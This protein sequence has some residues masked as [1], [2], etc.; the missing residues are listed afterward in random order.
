MR[1]SSCADHRLQTVSCS[2]AKAGL[3][4][5]QRVASSPLASTIFRRLPT[6]IVNGSDHACWQTHDASTQPALLPPREQN[7]LLNSGR[8]TRKR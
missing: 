3:D 1:S 7:R 2:D 8:V 6:T 4:L 5:P